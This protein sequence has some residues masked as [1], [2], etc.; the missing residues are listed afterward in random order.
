MVEK[1]IVDCNKNIEDNYDRQMKLEFELREKRQSMIKNISEGKE[2]EM[3]MGES[4]FGDKKQQK[5]DTWGGGL[6]NMTRGFF[7]R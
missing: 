3:M 7:N 4:G 6:G 5:K 1:Q 2:D